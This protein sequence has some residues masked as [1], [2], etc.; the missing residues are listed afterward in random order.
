MIVAWKMNF[1]VK[2]YFEYKNFKIKFQQFGV[3][4]LACKNIVELESL[5]LIQLQGMDTTSFPAKLC[6]SDLAWYSDVTSKLW[7]RLA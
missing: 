1:S 5:D 4:L 6:E 2:N 3:E 7:K